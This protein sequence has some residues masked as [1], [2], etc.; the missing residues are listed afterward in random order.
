MWGFLNNRCFEPAGF[1]AT[2]SFY[3]YLKKLVLFVTLLGEVKSAKQKLIVGPRILK[4]NGHKTKLCFQIKPG[5]LFLFSFLNI[6][7]FLL[8]LNSVCFKLGIRVGY[9]CTSPIYFQ[10]NEHVQSILIKYMYLHIYLKNQLW[11]Y[12]IK[13]FWNQDQQKCKKENNENKGKN[14]MES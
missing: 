1:Q 5:V 2:A 14:N 10:V 7:L 11:N 8:C 3:I 9:L 6:K 13:Y 12:S 4:L